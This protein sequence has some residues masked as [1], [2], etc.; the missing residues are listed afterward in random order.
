MSREIILKGVFNLTVNHI[1]IYTE[2]EWERISSASSH[3]IDKTLCGCYVDEFRISVY[4]RDCDL[5]DDHEHIKSRFCG[6]CLEKLN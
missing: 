6:I 2:E 5:G 4:D 3:R 1:S